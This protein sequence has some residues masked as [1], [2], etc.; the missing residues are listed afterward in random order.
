MHAKFQSPHTVARLV[1]DTSEI[2]EWRKH[3]YGYSDLEVLYEQRRIFLAKTDVVD[4]ELDP[5]KEVMVEGHF[6][7][8]VDFLELHGPAVLNHSRCDHAILASDEDVKRLDRVKEIVG[9]RTTSE[10]SATHDLHDAMHIATSIRY[11]YDGFITGEKR[12]IGRNDQFLSEFGF[13]IMRVDA[14][15]A[16]VNEL[17]RR[18]ER[19]DGLEWPN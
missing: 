19:R 13:R 11:G 10:R 17:I 9:I 16:H 1:L 18:Q 2:I 6:L 8:S 15:V 12:L 4:T 5:N 3:P 7:S 14:A